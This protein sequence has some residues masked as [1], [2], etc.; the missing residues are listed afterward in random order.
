MRFQ[1]YLRVLSDE[2][3][4]RTLYNETNV[5]GAV[6]KRLKAPKEGTDETWWNWETVHV[7]IDQSDVDRGVRAL[8]E[9]YQPLFADIKQYR[10]PEADTYLELITF[11]NE[12]E[13]P[14][15][16]CLSVESIS[17]LNELGAAFDNDS[18]PEVTL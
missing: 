7:D 15:G 14:T 13:N 2:A 9:Q 17:L 8:L 4:I 16:F 5:P 12:H 1:A 6:I 11:Y 10:G 18:V 3:T